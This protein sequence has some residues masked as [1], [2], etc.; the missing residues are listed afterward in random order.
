MRNVSAD[1]FTKDSGG[2]AGANGATN[3]APVAGGGDTFYRIRLRVNRY[4]LHGVPN[5][6]HPTPGMPVVADIKVGKRTI[7]RYLLS[8]VLPVATEGMREP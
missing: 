3:E 7:L 1:S 8:T 2:Q 4:T 6:F 5:Y